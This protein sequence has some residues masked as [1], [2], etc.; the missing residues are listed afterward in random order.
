MDGSETKTQLLRQGLSRSVKS[1]YH[2]VLFRKGDKPTGARPEP[3][4]GREQTGRRPASEMGV[5]W[6]PASAL[7]L[8]LLQTWQELPGSFRFCH[9]CFVLTLTPCLVFSRSVSGISHCGHYM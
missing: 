8:A 9:S 5:A 1:S 4:C 3:V 6:L 2:G 7:E